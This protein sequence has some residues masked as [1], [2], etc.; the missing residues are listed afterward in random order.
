MLFKTR[1]V[2]RSST[3]VN[4]MPYLN[5]QHSFLTIEDCE[6][7]QLCPTKKSFEKADGV[8]Y[9][10]GLALEDSSWLE[11]LCGKTENN[12]AEY[13]AYLADYDAL[14]NSIYKVPYHIADY[15]SAHKST[16]EKYCYKKWYIKR[17]T[18][19]CEAG[20]ITPQ[21]D[22]NLFINFCYASAGGNNEYSRREVLHYDQCREALDKVLA[23]RDYKESSRY[24]RAVMSDSLRYD[25]M[26]RDGFRCTICGA[27]A[28]DGA[29]LH[30]DHIVPVSKGGRTEM[31]NLRTL[32]DRCNLGKR[33]KIETPSQP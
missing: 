27:S 17:E 2:R 22:F 10:I 13:E 15:V 32:C 14:M 30:V 19:L 5:V 1:A 7:T 33:D 4:A 11:K 24:Q 12:R 31:D 23:K 28:A 18:R 26:Q 9:I 8:S 25:I 29:I 3:K 21:L 20:K 16:W 6:L